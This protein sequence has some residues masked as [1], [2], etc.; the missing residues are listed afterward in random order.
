MGRK[1]RPVFLDSSCKS[2]S[3]RTECQKVPVAVSHSFQPG[4]NLVRTDFEGMSELFDRIH[5]KE[6]YGF[7]QGV[8]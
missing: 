4:L 2:D 1:V 5:R 8:Y 3:M 6:I 7:N